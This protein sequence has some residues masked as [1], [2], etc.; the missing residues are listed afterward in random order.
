M[1][2]RRIAFLSLDV[3]LYEPTRASLEFF[4]PRLAEGGAVFLDDYGFYKTFP[5]AGKAVDEY[6]LKAP[7]GYFLRMPFGS[8]LIIK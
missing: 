2:D 3:D 1:T 5:G 6:L 7:H 8:A 4:F